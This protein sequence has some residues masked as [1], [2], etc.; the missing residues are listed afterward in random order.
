M[1]LNLAASAKLCRGQA[2]LWDGSYTTLLTYE[3]F[4]RAAFS[5]VLPITT[6]FKVTPKEGIDDGGWGAARQLRL[7]LV[8]AGVLGVAIV[9]RCL[10]LAGVVGL[11]PLHGV[12]VVAGLAFGAWELLMVLAALWRVTRRHQLRLHYRVP[13]EVAGIMGRS[14]VRVVDLTPGGAGVIGPHQMDLGSEVELA[15][16]LPTV[17][18]DIREVRVQF[19]VC[20]CRLAEG[21]GWRM[22]GTLV[23][24][25]EADGEVLIDHCHL[26]TSRHR[27][28]EAGRLMPG[29]P[30]PVP[31]DDRLDAVPLLS[32]RG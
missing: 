28:T 14:L 13:V 25:S 5:L 2:S 29:A 24:M 4:T 10:A 30:L 15:I 32:A 18:G 3:I 21:L 26:V 12:A 20:S 1:A 16:D 23:P 19:T 27:L 31:S 9:A 7:V 17:D 6:S 22:G 8:L 11:P